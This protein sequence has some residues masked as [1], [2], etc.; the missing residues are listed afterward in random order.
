MTP[1][2]ASLRS[3]T[4]SPQAGRGGSFVL[5][6]SSIWRPASPLRGEVPEHSEG[7]EGRFQSNDA[8]QN[9]A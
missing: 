1:H 3:A 2:P 9:E 7:G 6:P 4:L 5:N 8:F